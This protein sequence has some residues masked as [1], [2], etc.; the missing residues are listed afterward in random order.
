M[1]ALRHQPSRVAHTPVAKRTLVNT[2][3]A[4]ELRRANARLQN[5]LAACKREIAALRQSEQRFRTLVEQSPLSTQICAPDGSALFVNHAWEKL[6]DTTLEQIGDYNVLRDEQLMDHGLRADIERGFAGEPTM[7]PP[8]QYEPAKSAATFGG[9]Q[10]RWVRAVMYPVKN[11]AGQVREVVFQHEDVTAQKEAETQYQRIFEAT[12]DGLIINSMDGTILAANAALCEMHGYAAEELIGQHPNVIIHPDYRQAFST[13]FETTQ[14]DGQY[15]AR[16]VDVRKDGSLLHVEVQGSR[17]SYNGQPA[18]LGVIRDITER[19]EAYQLLEQ[20]VAE[21]TRELTTLLDV[22]R[23]VAS[24]LELQPLLGVILD[25]LKAV[26][27][28]RASAIFIL[29]GNN[30]LRLMSYRGPISQEQLVW[31]WLLADV[32]HSREVVLRREAVIIDDVHA[33]TPLARAFRAKAMQDLGEVPDYIASWMGVPLIHRNHIIGILAIDH[34]K[35][36][37]YTQ[38][39]A[40]LALAFANQAAIAIENARLYEQIQN[41]A[42]LQERQKLA[43]ELHDSVSQALFGIALG[44][45]TARTLLDRDPTK[46]ADPLDYVL[47]LAEAGLAEMRA[48]IFELRPESLETEGLVAALTK[49]AASLKARHNIEAT[50]TLCPEPDVPLAVKEALYRIGQEALHNMVKHARATHVDV[51]MVCNERQL[52]LTICDDGVGFD[53]G[54]DFPG[55]L[56]LRSMRERVARLGGELAIISEPGQGTT[57]SATVPIAP[58]L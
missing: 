7:L 41:A 49:Q 45:R 56:G 31:E 47:S 6:W 44:A 33:D 38:H 26:V 37:D 53:P 29:E 11:D 8:I 28:H 12:C 1:A 10:Q 36:H 48:L 42:A 58:S 39:H 50:T 19:V 2:Q 18:V 15:R 14:R 54:G 17:F 30:T 3:R 9:V 57:I 24:T 35:P 51:I 52:F 16:A 34:D 5:E 40:E 46:A 23:N 4:L 32:L 21:R 22:S 13:F 55:H 20:R 25:Q 27:D 43:R